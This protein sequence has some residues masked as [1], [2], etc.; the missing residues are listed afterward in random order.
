MKNQ[1]NYTAYE[2]IAGTFRFI[3]HRMNP[4][5]PVQTA[6]AEYGGCRPSEVIPDRNYFI[7]KIHKKRQNIT[8]TDKTNGFLNWCSDL[9]MFMPSIN[10]AL[11]PPRKYIEQARTNRLTN[12]VQQKNSE[13][14]NI[15]TRPEW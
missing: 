1:V 11:E 14:D 4:S 2:Q 10:K 5:L 15:M 9:V 3:L 13:E 7:E 12:E 8:L 6:L